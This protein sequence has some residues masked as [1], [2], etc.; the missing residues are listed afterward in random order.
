MMTL[1]RRRLLKTAAATGLVAATAPFGSR[2]LRAQGRPFVFVSW[3]GALS[4]LEKEVFMD[5]ASKEFK[6]EITNTSPTNYAKIKAMV[7]GNSVEWDLVNVGGRFIFQG[8]DQGL[9][10]QIGRAHV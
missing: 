1:N 4:A 10:E 5:P 3:G 6:T 2:A 8:R 7:E 9:L